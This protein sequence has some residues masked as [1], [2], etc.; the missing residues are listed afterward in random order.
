MICEFTIRQVL[1]PGC[2]VESLN[3][4]SFVVNSQDEK[5]AME[6][7]KRCTS[8]I[9]KHEQSAA[10]EIFLECLICLSESVSKTV[11]GASS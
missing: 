10:P 7:T 6:E 2:I 5:A 4:L 11:G 9:V 8:S 1:R 3:G